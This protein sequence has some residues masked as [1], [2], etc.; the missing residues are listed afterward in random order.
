MGADATGG[1]NGIQGSLKFPVRCGPTI[2]KSGPG[3]ACLQVPTLLAGDQSGKKASVHCSRDRSTQLEVECTT[4]S[5]RR[6]RRLQG[7]G[8]GPVRPS[9]CSP[10][11][12][13]FCEPYSPC[14][15][16]HLGCRKGSSQLGLARRCGFFSPTT[17]M[18]C[19]HSQRQVTICEEDWNW[20]GMC[21]AISKLATT[22]LG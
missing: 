16:L 7:P 8:R 20:P 1:D 4:C 13:H 14:S 5:T 10:R 2:R 3:G 15:S 12:R 19:I 9:R 21:L 11:R 18:E 17:R 22:W 6:S